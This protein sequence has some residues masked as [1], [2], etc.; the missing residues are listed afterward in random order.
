MRLLIPALLVIASCS[1]YGC[2]EPIRPIEPIK[3]IAPIEQRIDRKTVT[4]TVTA[5]EFVDGHSERVY[6]S[7]WSFLKKKRVREWQTK[8]YPGKGH[9]EVET[10]LIALQSNEIARVKQARELGLKVGD[11]VV[12]VYDETYNLVPDKTDPTKKIDEFIESQ[13]TGFRLPIEQVDKK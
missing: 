8:Y 11:T 10:P 4:G 3:P 13:I 5:L 9:I 1:L 12:V 7:R 2:E 6:G